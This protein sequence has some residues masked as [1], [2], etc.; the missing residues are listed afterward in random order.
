MAKEQAAA[1][2]FAEFCKFESATIL[3]YNATHNQRNVLC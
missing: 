3:M 2:Q 1:V